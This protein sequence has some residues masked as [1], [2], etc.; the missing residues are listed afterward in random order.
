MK[1][2]TKK[3]KTTTKAS[4]ERTLKMM[5]EYVRLFDEEGMGPRQIAK[6][7]GLS[8]VTVY[9]HLDEI[10]EANNR[11]RESLLKGESFRKHLVKTK[12]PEPAAKATSLKD[13]AEQVLAN[14]NLDDVVAGMEAVLEKSDSQYSEYERKWEDIDQIV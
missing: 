9:L 1:K 13:L 5:K 14:K 11:S 6:Y 12:G 4:H 3:K 10:A 2:T 8:D 7:F